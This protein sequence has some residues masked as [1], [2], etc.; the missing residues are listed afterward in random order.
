MNG[1][2]CAVVVRKWFKE[3]LVV[4]E[5]CRRVFSGLGQDDGVNLCEKHAGIQRRSCVCCLKIGLG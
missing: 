3:R 2:G 5:E 4:N 1:T